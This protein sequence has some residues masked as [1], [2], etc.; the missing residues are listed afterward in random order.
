MSRAAGIV[1]RI[2]RYAAIAASIWFAAAAA[3]GMFGMPGG[4]HIDAGGAAT[5]MMAEQ[6]VRWK[7]LYPAFDWFTNVAPPPSA[8]YCHH[9]FGQ[10]WSSA[11][12]VW[13][14]GPKDF[15]IHLPAV[16][17][18]TAIPPLLY[19]IGKRHW[20]SV[21]GAAAACAYVVVPIALGFS[22]YHNLET[23]VI[24]GSLLFFWGHSSHQA[25]GKRRYL[26]ASLSGLAVAC[27]GDWVGYLVAAPLL[28]WSMLRAFV[29]P[30]RFTPPLRF[31]PY[32]R[33]WA[34]SVA[35]SV[36]S[37]AFWVAMFQRVG[38]VDDWLASATTRGDHGSGVLASALDSRKIWIEFSF[39]PLAI[40]VGK[41][42]APFCALRLAI[43]RTDE[44]AYALAILFAAVVQYV[45][46]RAGADVHIYWP[47]YFAAYFALAFAQFLASVQGGA[48][49][50]A[51]RVHGARLTAALGTA[52]LVLALGTCLTMLPDAVRSLKIWR[53]TGGRYNDKGTL[54]RTHR[55]LL[56]VLR[57]VVVPATPPG[58]SINVHES[59]HWGWEHSWVYR[60]IGTP[61]GMPTLGPGSVAS[62]FWVARASGFTADQLRLL[63]A[64][65]HV[66]WYG[67]TLIVDQR[68]PA[69][70][71]DAFSLNEREPNFMECALY[72]NWE[73]MRRIDPAPD[74]FAT[75]EYRIHLGQAADPPSAGPVT[76]D[77]TRI[78]HN[79][80][81]H[82][83]DEATAG[84]LRAAIESQLDRSVAAD[85]D[86]GVRLI[87]VRIAGK[88]SPRL[89]AWFEAGGPTA[90]DAVFNI[91]SVVEHKAPWSLIPPDGVA[92]NMAW[93]PS[94][95]PKLWRA[96]FIYVI[97]AVM[98]HR[99]GLE[100]YYAAFTARGSG[101]A[102][103][104]LDG[105][106]ETDLARVP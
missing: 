15:V 55:D 76:I 39:T 94:L 36:V 12:F 106:P 80:A 62:P 48:G 91:A 99:I 30:E 8:Y 27:A 5:A 89:E 6:I 73:P 103:H 44:E 17:M 34:L 58:A 43:R 49:W 72:G 37:L 65:A 87:G 60:G 96:R 1:D 19:G 53:L 79:A 51:A 41:I 32:V 7:I 40:L 56:F 4:G 93:P 24:F 35:L 66:R 33:W 101:A 22:S 20:G 86:Q 105:K 29:I 88:G 100:R 50:V 10:Y 28:G 67:D 75:W 61:A 98:N 85:F 84:R 74:P 31:K 3:W 71:V 77:Q 13:L 46:F 83:G 54:I 9:P 16:L 68:E 26:V 2:A 102:P 52:G 92:R 69:A 42:A 59:A 63:T 57:K 90:S 95:S 81:I 18:S 11:F 97:D 64:G 70:P 104:R 47:H 45:V 78:A 23:M 38:K 14:F 21:G 82:R 25:T